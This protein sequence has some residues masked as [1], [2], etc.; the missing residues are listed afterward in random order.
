LEELAA[1]KGLDEVFLVLP[2]GGSDGIASA[3]IAHCEEQGIM[4]RVIT[5][6]ADLTWGHVIVDEVAGQPV[7]SIFSG[8]PHDAHLAM[9]RVIDIIIAAIG[10]LMSL[11]LMAL[12]AIAIKLDSGGPVFFRQE[13][14]GMNRRRFTAYKFRTMVED[15]DAAQ[16]ALENLNE[17]NGPVFKIKNDPRITRV[18]EFLRR[19]SIDELPQLF[20][21]I[22]NDM[23]LV[24]P[25]PLPVRDVEKMDVRWHRRR[26]A[27]KPGITC[28]WQAK[29]REPKFDDWIKSDMEYID[30]WSLSLD[31]RILLKT[32]PAVIMRQ[33]A[34]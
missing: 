30:S 34:H 7:L 33:G 16:A 19:S 15:A 10:I 32:I 11:P 23:S 3:L 25:R 18:G 31:M 5:R 21:V 14:I 20:N 1:T 9:K 22:K 17:A 12:A 29:S 24:G 13:R 4:V 26:F 2:I 27:V 6:I 8:P 28:I